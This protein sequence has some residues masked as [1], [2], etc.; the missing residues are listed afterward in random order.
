M[1]GVCVCTVS[2]EGGKSGGTNLIV[3]V[4][5]LPWDGGVGLVKEDCLQLALLQLTPHED[6]W[7]YI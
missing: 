5:L 6:S 3:K 7:T 4:R 1:T 2:V